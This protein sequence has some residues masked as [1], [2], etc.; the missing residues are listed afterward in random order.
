MQKASRRIP[1]AP[2]RSH[3]LPTGLV[4]LLFSDIEGSTERWKR[5]PETMKVALRKHDALMHEAIVANRGYV[6]KT[7]GDEFCAVFGGVHDAICAAVQAQCALAETDWSDVGGLRVRMAI[8]TGLA[9]ERDNDYYGTTVNRVARLLAA[10]HGDQ[11]LI[12]EAGLDACGGRY[13]DGVEIRDLGRHRLKDFPDLEAIH[14]VT[15]AGLPSVFPP[16]RTIAERPT[17]IPAELTPLIGR[18]ED[19]GVLKD[20]LKKN[21]VQSIVGAGGIGKTSL[22][23]RAGADVLTEFED[24][25]WFVELAALTQ[26][27]EVAGAVAAALGITAGG[28][29]TVLDAVI[30]YLKNKSALLIVD[31]C[32]HLTGAVAKDVHAL[33]RAAPAVRVL[34][35]TR[36]P[37]GV[38]GEGVYRLPSLAVPPPELQDPRAIGG[39]GAVALFVDRARMQVPDFALTDANARIVANICRRLDGIALAIELAAPRLRVLPVDQL[40]ARLDERFRILTGGSRTA[41]PRQ[42]TLRALIDWSYDLLSEP[43]RTLFRRVALFAA[44]W[45]LGAAIEV[46]GDQVLQA[47]ELLDHLTTLVDKSL[48]VFDPAGE[49]RY[50]LLE[51]TREYA[52][53]RLIECGERDAIAGK[54][55]RYYAGLARVA[56]EKWSDTPAT[57]WIA[58]LK[59]ELDNFRTALTWTLVQRHDVLLGI[60][61]FDAL[62]AFWW[63][64]QPIE[65][66]RWIAEA[67]I[68]VG[69]LD[70]PALAAKFWLTAANVALTLRQQKT[71]LDA[72]RRAL[73][74]YGLL[75]DEIGSAAALRCQGAALINLGHIDEGEVCVAAALRT[76]RAKGNRRLTA[77]A[78]RSL[79]LAPR[80]RGETERAAP[81]QREALQLARELEDERGIQIMS[82]NLAEVECDCG[83]Y[84]EAIRL[85]S[86]ALT[87]ARDRH[88][89]IFMCGALINLAAYYIAQERFA[90]ARTTAREALDVSIEIESEL[91]F[92]IAVQHIAV[93]AEISGDAP[94]SARLLGYSDAAFARAESRREPT[95][96]REYE[97]CAARLAVRLSDADL[98]TYLDE[99]AA[100]DQA[101][102]RREALLA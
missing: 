50:H 42:Q 89:A 16:L 57:A 28:T 25:V 12:S 90:D 1:S 3:T 102:A 11:V 17:N 47:W 84:D 78:L 60:E 91:H 9:D 37:L 80:L 97:A 5:Y 7:V 10:A 77:L 46:C 4:T 59:D 8:H 30:S 75:G 22:A 81:I 20:L 62:E 53:E 88:D 38:P 24:G 45:T 2:V 76:F 73:D 86:E 87:I 31:N 98:R 21:R 27:A 29:G 67:V 61:L 83:N 66:R 71:A 69:A 26:D 44:G 54:H 94:R 64:A 82:G 14:Q 85:S 74:A 51:S 36:E 18:D 40:E 15:G 58:P 70:A 55:A 41:L 6:F 56:D 95:E 100:W 48:V 68:Q 34:C 92:A 72:A 33:V 13:P 52:T 39:F 96:A 93:V 79:G 99:G 49:G 101:A 63:D 43:E 19:L 65:G 35:T 32:E 23:L